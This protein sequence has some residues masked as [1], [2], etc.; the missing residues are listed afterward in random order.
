MASQI[1]KHMFK[2]SKH[3][4]SKV[5][6]IL[7]DT[8]DNSSEQK[9]FY[10]D[11][12]VNS[13]LSFKGINYLLINEIIQSGSNKIIQKWPPVKN[14]SILEQLIKVTEVSQD[15]SSLMDKIEYSFT[16]LKDKIVQQI[17]FC[18]KQMMNK[19]SNLPLQ[20]QDILSQYQQLS[21]IHKLR[22]YLLQNNVDLQEI[23]T[24]CRNLVQSMCSQ[25][26]SNTIQLQSIL[27]VCQSSRSIL[28]FQQLES[29]QSVILDM[30]TSIDLFNPNTLSIKNLNDQQIQEQQLQQQVNSEKSYEK[31]MKLID[32][33]SNYCSQEFLQ[34]LKKVL[35]Q[36]NPFLDR[37]SG[38]DNMFIADKRPIDFSELNNNQLQLIEE[39]INHTKQLSQNDYKNNICNSDCI[40]KCKKILSNKMNVLNENF[41]EQFEKFLIDTF[42]FLS[43]INF[44]NYIQDQNIFQCLND[45][46]NHRLSDLVDISKKINE[47]NQN[48]C[49]IPFNLSASSSEVKQQ[50]TEFYEETD[51]DN[52]LKKFP[53]FDLIQKKKEIISIPIQLIKTSYQNGQ[54]AQEIFINNNQ[55]YEVVQKISNQWNNCVSNIILD[56]NSKYIFR[57]K[58]QG[59]DGQ[60]YMIGLTSDSQK[61]IQSG[62]NDYFSCYF[63][64][65]DGT[66]KNSP[67]CNY[68]IYKQQKGDRFVLN[69]E[70]TLEMRVCIKEKILE[71]YDYPNYQYCLSLDDKYLN[72]LNKQDLRLY[73]GLYQYN[74]RMILMESLKVRKF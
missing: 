49:Q 42:P 71:V 16:Q 44:I 55:Q 66:F 11:Y 47:I 27:Q 43:K 14:H 6:Y 62:F 65:N 18:Q 46:S 54:N 21:Q 48:N 7:V 36:L 57:I 5:K 35:E 64:K 37:V 69:E 22:S 8:L 72:N 67:G 13:D 38:I 45:L 40:I 17:D 26:E 10:C 58:I 60:Y 25:K 50:L 32:N 73:L 12:C 61:D 3:P 53:I 33:K 19:A 15:E 20:K 24:Y 9:M 70:N 30:I 4:N 34:P 23:E 68:G 74:D 1:Q 51:L 59:G 41:T 28:N 56:K 63:E 52:I 29:I 2:C 39:Y 31:I